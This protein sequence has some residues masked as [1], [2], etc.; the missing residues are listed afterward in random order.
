MADKENNTKVAENK[1]TATPVSSEPAVKPEEESVRH[2]YN[3]AEEELKTK[4]GVHKVKVQRAFNE[5]DESK[6]IVSETVTYEYQGKREQTR[7]TTGTID[8]YSSFSGHKTTTETFQNDKTYDS[9]GRLKKSVESHKSETVA[10]NGALG[11]TLGNTAQYGFGNE[12]VTTI[13]FDKNEQMT[14]THT[15]HSST[16]GSYVSR[17]DEYTEFKRN[18]IKNSMRVE[19]TAAELVVKAQDEAKK[20]EFNAYVKQNGAEHYSSTVKG[21][22]MEIDVDRDGKVSG[23]IHAL[24]TDGQSV[25]KSMPLSDKELRK[26]L[27]DMRKQAD[28]TIQKVSNAKTAEE[29]LTSLPTPANI[30]RISFSTLWNADIGKVQAVQPQVQ[31][32]YQQE[33]EARKSQPVEMIAQNKLQEYKSQR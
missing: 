25:V 16:S 15:H 3:S 21:K 8:T 18:E 7:E 2:S 33:I 17:S 20:K 26:S 9:K 4:K 10:D 31:A 14:S 1:E 28:Q 29:Y 5:V 13:N 24:S 22:M 27:K 23:K 12:T 6:P 30:G 11:V 32:Q 19:A